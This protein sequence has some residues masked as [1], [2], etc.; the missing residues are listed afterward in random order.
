M[1]T[2]PDFQSKD[3]EAKQ[4]VSALQTYGCCVIRGIAPKA[5]LTEIA[6][7][8]E[9]LYQDMEQRHKSNE[10]SETEHR[11]CYRYGIIRPFEKDCVL[12]SGK[13]MKEAMLS[14]L[15][16]SVL[17]D[18]YA[19]FFETKELNMLIPSSHL[20]RVKKEDAA[21]YH[22][23]ASVMKLQKVH[24]LNSWFPLDPAGID[25]PCV[26][27]IPEAQVHCWPSG[28]KNNGGLYGHLEIT[29]EKIKER[30]TAELWQPVLLPGDVLLL[31]SYTI[32]QTN[33]AEHMTKTRR[34][35]ELRFGRR[36][37]LGERSDI[38]QLE[39]DFS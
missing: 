23:D 31:H 3:V 27:I 2:V 11:H 18:A 38:N 25:A 12:K 30:L 33:A 13:S 32:H 35:F 19:E 21:P 39:V 6:D 34:D 9:D 5:L 24:F 37:V 7:C 10:M 15:L 36:S 22:Q 16:D 28:L 4:I 8:S 17:K 29:K 14:C 20:R 1:S 26:E